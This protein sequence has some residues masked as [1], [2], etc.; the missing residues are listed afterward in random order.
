[1]VGFEPRCDAC[2]GKQREQC[3]CANLQQAV[4]TLGAQSLV[5]KLE[6]I[7]IEAEY[8]VTMVRLVGQL[9]LHIFIERV[10]RKQAGGVVA[11]KQAQLVG[12]LLNE[13]A[14]L[15]ILFHQ[16]GGHARHGKAILF[17][18]LQPVFDFVYHRVRRTPF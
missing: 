9:F 1:M 5:D 15:F 17:G 2:F 12:L 4:A 14:L 8:V 13:R 7:H 16:L 11:F 10:A 6:I 3:V 18:I